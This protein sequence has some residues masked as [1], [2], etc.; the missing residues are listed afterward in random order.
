MSFHTTTG[1]FLGYALVQLPGFL[2]MLFGCTRN[3]TNASKDY[4]QR[5]NLNPDEKAPNSE[6]SVPVEF[7]YTSPPKSKKKSNTVHA[8][9]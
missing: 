8:S 9:Y 7:R 5:N 2:F 3:P 4:D 6:L 1:M